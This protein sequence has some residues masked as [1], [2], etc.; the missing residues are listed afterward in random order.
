MPVISIEATAQ[1]WLILLLLPCLFLLSLL[2]R[3]PSKTYMTSHLHYVYFTSEFCSFLFS[4]PRNGHE[5]FYYHLSDSSPSLTDYM[6]LKYELHILKIWKTAF[7][8]S[9]NWSQLFSLESPRTLYIF[10]Q[11]SSYSTLCYFTNWAIIFQSLYWEN[12]V[13]INL[14][15]F[16][17][18]LL[19]RPYYSHLFTNEKTE[20]E[21]FFVIYPSS[22]TW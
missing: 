15:N 22:V 8:Q 20:A 17:K 3:N 11:Y 10:W 7:F 6:E 12:F 19:G 4:L 21:R 2:T 9:Y 1:C 13:W 18:F 16:T 5:S 14:L